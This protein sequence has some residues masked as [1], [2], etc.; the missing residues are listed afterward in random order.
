M[1][2]SAQRLPRLGGPFFGHLRSFRSDRFGLLLRIPEALGEI[3]QVRLGVIDAVFVSGPSAAE[4]VLATRAED[5]KKSRGIS[6]FARPLIGS[7]LL[8][9]EGAL[10]RVRRKQ[11]A[12]AFFPKRV[13]AYAEAIAEETD[14]MIDRL[15]PAIDVQ[16]EMMQLTLR[17][18]GRALFHTS[19][20]AD[21]ERV[22]SAFTRANEGMMKML[23]APLP[24]P[25]MF[26]TRRARQMKR[27]VAELDA[28]IYRVIRERRASSESHQDVLS[29]LLEGLEGEDGA[30][31][32]D[33]ALRDEVMTLFLA[34]HETTANALSWAILETAARPELRQRLAA[35]ADAAY[36]TRRPTAADLGKLP[37]AAA[38]LKESMRLWPP[39]YLTGRL[40]LVDTEILGHRIPRGTTVFINIAGIHRRPDLFPEPLLFHPQRFLDDAERSWPRCAYLPFGAGPRICIGSHLA[41]LEGT[42]ALSRI[43]QRLEWS[44]EGLPLPGVEPMITLRPKSIAPMPVQRR[45]RA[46]V[47]FL[48]KT[49]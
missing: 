29:M 43:A 7:G 15:G 46:E 34:G 31:L 20:E 19:F 26:P 45:T 41:L 28:V 16:K 42:L 24:L 25:P 48:F 33:Q 10:H 18:V 13:A 21:V 3:G 23:S 6:L 14:L 35:E 5:Y 39:A 11:V 17:I 12:P 36:G 47:P 30:P 38:V 22:D 8:S 49:A 37:W 4:T 1:D 44:R 32:G 9:S 27:A 2:T 40:A